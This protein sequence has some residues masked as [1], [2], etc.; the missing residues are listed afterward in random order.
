MIH[1]IGFFDALAVFK[2]VRI[3]FHVYTRVQAVCVVLKAATTIIQ[4]LQVVIVVVQP[5][6]VVIVVVQH[7]QVVIVVVQHLQVVIVVFLLINTLT[8]LHVALVGLGIDEGLGTVAA[9]EASLTSNKGH[10]ILVAVW[11]ILRKSTE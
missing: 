6:Q 9:L 3:V 5:L 7:L 8:D 4:H 11:K 2:I 1:V 10:Q